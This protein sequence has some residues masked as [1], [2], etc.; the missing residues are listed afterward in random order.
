M[1]ALAQRISRSGLLGRP[2]VQKTG[3]GLGGGISLFCSPWSC[4]FSWHVASRPRW[5]ADQQGESRMVDEQTEV[6][7]KGPA[8]T[9]MSPEVAASLGLTSASAATAPEGPKLV[10]AS[11]VK[12]EDVGMLSLRYVDGRPVLAVTGGPYIPAGIRAEVSGE[13]SSQEPRIL[14]FDLGGG[15]YDV[16]VLDY[17]Y[18][19]PSPVGAGTLSVRYAGGRPALVVS[20]GN[21][22]PGTVA[23]VNR[24]GEAVGTY[25]AGPEARNVSS[26]STVPK[27]SLPRRAKRPRPTRPPRCP[28]PRSPG[29]GGDPGDVHA[30]TLP[31]EREGGGGLGDTDRG[32]RR[33]H[34]ETAS[35]P[36][37]NPPHADTRIARPH[38]GTA[39]RP[40][41]PRGNP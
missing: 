34:R 5:R 37:R 26:K 12:P 24:S 16:S 4:H 36:A 35:G 31:G 7:S 39:T 6:N 9:Q 27:I 33:T 40:N 21:A 14:V 18:D 17:A 10:P 29:A 1:A 22:V 38:I 23:V 25:T 15:T 2:C 20:G 19:T 8:Q 41:N 28:P 3:L 32:R 30:G 13:P 11:E